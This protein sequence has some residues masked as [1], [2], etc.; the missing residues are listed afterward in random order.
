[1]EA[2]GINL[3]SRAVRWRARLPDP[4]GGIAP[5]LSN[6][7]GTP[8]VLATQAISPKP[9]RSVRDARGRKWDV[10]PVVFQGINR[11]RRKKHFW[12]G[13]GPGGRGSHKTLRLI[14]RKRSIER[15][16][17]RSKEFTLEGE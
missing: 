8:S 7:A 17:A 9:P 6:N 12:V 2:Q 3:H 1:M 4:S 10:T 16:E 15:S 11:N 13:R 14:G 5:R